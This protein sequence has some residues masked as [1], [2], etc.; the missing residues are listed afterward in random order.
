MKN[1]RRVLA[2]FLSITM[3][4]SLSVPAL[5]ASPNSI[6][7]EEVLEAMA[8]GT[9][10]VTMEERELSSYTAEEIAQDEGLQN[11]FNSLGPITRST[12]DRVAVGVLYTTTVQV[13]GDTVKFMLHP[14]AEIHAADVATAGGS[15]ISTDFWAVEQITVNGVITDDW[16][17]L[18]WLNNIEGSLGCGNNSVFRNETNVLESVYISNTEVFDI[19]A[20][21]GTIASVKDFGATSAIV[22]FLQG[23]TYSGGYRQSKSI[24]T[25]GNV[26]A[27]GYEWKPDIRIRD[28]ADF[29]GFESTLCTKDSSLPRSQ[30]A[31]AA[32]L[33]TF[34]VYFGDVTGAPK[35][36]NVTLSPSCTYLVNV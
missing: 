21:I 15:P 26:R 33:W 9:A 7:E 35:Y 19:L 34:D 31:N 3:L 6:T 17:N 24:G 2:L 36:T 28:S 12:Y 4:A 27:I 14:R 22:Q 5:A 32:A 25:T 20:L 18:I 16:E 10:I 13:G 11:I 1:M 8:N 30:S 29:L 23:I